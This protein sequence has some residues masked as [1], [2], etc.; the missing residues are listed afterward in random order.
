KA[1]R[2]SPPR[3]PAKWARICEKIVAHYIDGWADGFHH[4]ITYWEIWN[5]P[6]YGKDLY[7]D[8]PQ[9]FD[10]CPEEYFRLYEI[11]SKHLKS[12]FGDRIKVGGYAA[13]DVK[14]VLD[15]DYHSENV[16]YKYL[17]EFMNAFFAHVKKT[18]A[19]LDFF[20]WHSYREAAKTVPTAYGFREYLDGLG[21]I[22]T[23]SHLNEWNPV[24]DLRGT[25]RH[26]AQ[27]AAIMLGM[28]KAPIDLLTLYDARLCGSVYAALFDPYT[29]KPFHAYYAL[30][31]FDRLYKL[32]TEVFCECDTEGLYAVA[33]SDGKKRA[34]MISN[35]SDHSQPLEIEGADLSGASWHV[36]DQQRL[37]S[38]SP[39][40]KTIE[41]NGVVL[42]EF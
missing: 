30:V 20:S 37:L 34:L 17:G 6:E 14:P 13:M 2:T 42:V 8:V 1:Y 18:G 3:D 7:P 41:K 10:G 4:K 38:W 11:T 23:E 12:V 36:I 39:E 25:A 28:Q 27:V 31:A 26:S 32:K 24:H 15:P 33:A 40:V 9:M 22:K 35:V 29:L 21:F 5:E 19:P 16:K